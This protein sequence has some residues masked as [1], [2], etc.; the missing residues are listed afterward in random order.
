MPDDPHA[1]PGPGGDPSDPQLRDPL[2]GEYRDAL[3]HCGRWANWYKMEQQLTWGLSW[4]CTVLIMLVCIA[5]LG[6]TVPHSWREFSLDWVIW[7]LSGFGSLIALVEYR[8][9]AR[10]LWLRHRAAAEGMRQHAMKYQ[11][12]LDPYDQSS[13]SVEFKEAIGQLRDMADGKAAPPSKAKSS[14][15]HTTLSL[16]RGRWKCAWPA[17]CRRVRSHWRWI[18][19]KPKLPDPDRVENPSD[20]VKKPAWSRFGADLAT[21]NV[22]ALRWAEARLLDQQRWH[23]DKCGW[24]YFKDRVGQLAYILILLVAVSLTAYFGRTFVGTAVLTVLSLVL[25][26]I[27][28]FYAWG[29]ISLRYYL[30]ATSLRKIHL[31]YCGGKDGL[32]TWDGSLNAAGLTPD[33]KRE[34]IAAMLREVEELLDG[35]FQYWRF[36]HDPTAPVPRPAKP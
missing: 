11:F 23:E 20:S 24:Y 19:R 28:S 25:L 30:L 17:V 10:S 18:L 5:C 22:I 9:N 6:E 26:A 16:M 36:F 31:R 35:E 21:Q 4:L 13:A 1:P 12:G 29:P 8:R 27:P 7:I 15:Q 3:K 2:D 33:D 32:T 14:V 34:L